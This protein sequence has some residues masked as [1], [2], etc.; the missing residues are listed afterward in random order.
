NISEAI[1]LVD[2]QGIVRYI[3]PASERILGYSSAQRIGNSV[4]SNIADAE[5]ASTLQT[6]LNE[7]RAEPQAIRSF[8]LQAKHKDGSARWLEATATN[9]LDFDS[10]QAI[11]VNYR[12]VTERIHAEKEREKYIEELGKQNAERERF[13]Y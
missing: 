7:L 2:A 13:T 10:V 5:S 3:S 11:V 12:D 1:A 9:L 4:L 8:I 6:A